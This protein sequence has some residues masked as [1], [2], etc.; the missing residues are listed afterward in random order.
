MLTQCRPDLRFSTTVPLGMASRHRVLAIGA[1]SSWH[2]CKLSW[3][4]FRIFDHLEAVQVANGFSEAQYTVIYK[5]P[6]D[7]SIKADVP[8]CCNILICDMM[9]EGAEYSP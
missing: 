6:S 2:T 4:P 7:L 9:D 3:K 8:V 1:A 5:R